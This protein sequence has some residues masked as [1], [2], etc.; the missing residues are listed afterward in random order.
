[1]LIDTLNL[2]EGSTSTNLIIPSGTQAARLA[3]ASPDN[4]ELFYQT[5]GSIGLYVYDTST[6]IKLANAADVTTLLNAYLK[7][8]V[9]LN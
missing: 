8:E 2:T 9:L 5:D 1:M 3:L 4:G 7:K 6:W